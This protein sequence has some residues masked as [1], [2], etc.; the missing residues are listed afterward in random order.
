[1]NIKEGLDGSVPDQEKN[2]TPSKRYRLINGNILLE[3]GQGG[4]I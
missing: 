1:M 3:T 4:K 2:S